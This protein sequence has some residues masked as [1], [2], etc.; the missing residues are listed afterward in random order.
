LLRYAR[1]DIRKTSALL[2]NP[3]HC[4]GL[5]PELVEIIEFTLFSAENMH[6]D[7]AII[8]QEPAGVEAAF[9]VKRQDAF[10]FQALLDFIV[11]SAELPLAFAGANNEIVGKPADTMNVQ[12][13]DVAGLFIAGRVDGP[14]GYF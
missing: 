9:A 13:Y 3:E 12:Q 10:L 7:I 4:R 11:D 6:D 5:V 2:L 8:E 14:A 1:N